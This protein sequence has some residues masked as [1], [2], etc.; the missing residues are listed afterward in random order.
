MW[1]PDIQ[2][3]VELFGTM[4]AMVSVS[5]VLAAEAYVFGQVLSLLSSGADIRPAINHW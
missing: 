2:L 4:V 3:N 5:P 1:V